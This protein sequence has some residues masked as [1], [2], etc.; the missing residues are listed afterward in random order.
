MTTVSSEHGGQ[1]VSAGAQL[2]LSAT[3]GSPQLGGH[4]PLAGTQVE[5]K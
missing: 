1:R 5:V 4:L 2:A 3:P